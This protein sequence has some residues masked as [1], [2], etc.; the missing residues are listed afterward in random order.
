MRN[1]KNLIRKEFEAPPSSKILGGWLE[2]GITPHHPTG[3]F[4]G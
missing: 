1:L 3:I 4:Y 2:N